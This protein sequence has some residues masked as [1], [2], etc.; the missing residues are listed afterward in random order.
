MCILEDVNTHE[1]LRFRFLKLPY[2]FVIIQG[3]LIVY[4]T[5]CNNEIA[6]K[7]YLNKTA[8]MTE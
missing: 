8:K 7:E 3:R 1:K 5:E 6:K 2:S 4:K